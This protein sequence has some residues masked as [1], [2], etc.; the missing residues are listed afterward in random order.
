VVTEHRNRA[1]A[2]V[3]LFRTVRRAQA[4]HIVAT[5][6]FR[7]DT[8]LLKRLY[9]LFFIDIGRRSAWITRVT[10]HPNAPWVTQPARNVARDIADE[11]LTSSS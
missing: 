3:A 4:S 7:V 8:V 9:V 1:R 11:E 10:A 5:D 6:F 2:S